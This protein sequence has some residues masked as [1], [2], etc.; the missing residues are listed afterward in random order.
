MEDLTGQI[1]GRWKVL[2]KCLVT[3]KD[4]RVQYLCECSCEAHTRRL[5]VARS[6][7]NGTSKS[8]GCLRRERSSE[9]NKGNSYGKANRQDLSGKHFGHLTVIE[10]LNTKKSGSWEWKC[11][12]D[13]GEEVISNTRDLNAGRKTRCNTCSSNALI[14]KGEEAI[15]K[16]LCENNISFEK[17]K[18]FSS[19]IFPDT[20]YHAKFDF[21]V[22]NKYL[23]EFDG[24]QHFIISETSAWKEK[25]ERIQIRDTYKDEW[26]KE[27]NISLIRIPYT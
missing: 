19:C 26:C 16:L 3:S 11:M 7:K 22:D 20:K 15:E 9:A 13:C 14:S 1:F 6:L 8:C 17:Q 18:T 21:Y 5:V 10:R 27:N 25:E 24:E 4:N 23:I 12:C 2:E